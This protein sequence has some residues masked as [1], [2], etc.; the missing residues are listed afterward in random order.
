MKKMFDNKIKKLDTLDI[1]LIKLS[2][3][4]F[5]LWIL[6]IWPA[7]ATWVYSINPMYYLILW[8]IFAIRPISKILSK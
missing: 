1:S 7:F 6:T 8:I 3:I 4:A 2:V 5:T